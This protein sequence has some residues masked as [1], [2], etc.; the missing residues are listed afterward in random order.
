MILPHLIGIAQWFKIQI[1][2]NGTPNSYFP[3]AMNKIVTI[4]FILESVRPD[5]WGG[6]EYIKY[7]E[8]K[9]FKL[10]MYNC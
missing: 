5:Y 3:N 10:L 8:I 4:F 6:G 9:N 1:K 2:K 7:D